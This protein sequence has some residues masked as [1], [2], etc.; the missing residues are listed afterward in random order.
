[1]RTYWNDVTC[2]VKTYTLSNLYV[3]KIVKNKLED[4]NIFTE[5]LIIIFRIF[6]LSL[7]F[8][9]IAIKMTKNLIYEVFLWS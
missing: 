7:F 5:Y 4:Y 9:P 2:I 6:I 3:V 8:F 1:M